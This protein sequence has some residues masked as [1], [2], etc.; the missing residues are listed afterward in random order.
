M[1]RHVGKPAFYDEE[2]IPFGPANL[3]VVP[4]GDIFLV[5]GYGSSYVLHFDAD[6]N[7]LNRFGGRGND[8]RH[9]KWAHGIFYAEVDGEPLLHIAVDEPSLIK[10]FRLDGTYHSLL[11]GDFLHPRT[12]VAHGGLWAVAEMQGRVTLLPEAGKGEPVHLGF[13]GESMEDVFELRTCAR[14]E[15]LP[16]RFVSAHDI[17]F[18]PDG[19]MIVVEWV[20][21]GRV[22]RVRFH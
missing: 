10:R 5:E 17:A 2:K 13:S 16:G 22:N 12:L 4:S 8:P 11:L 3:C 15:F 9:T 20:E 6:G 7:L 14:E 21:C 18:F 19:D 1:L